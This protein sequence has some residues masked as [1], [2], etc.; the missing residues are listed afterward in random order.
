MVKLFATHCTGVMVLRNNVHCWCSSANGRRVMVVV[1]RCASQF[2]L[3]TEVK[4][5]PPSRSSL[6]KP[7]VK[8][9][10][11]T[12]FWVPS[13]SKDMIM[14]ILMIMTIIHGDDE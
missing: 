8:L 6:R 4:A 12:T 9:I 7:I 10:I 3:N 2:L 5:T 14:V 1:V 13:C 11:F